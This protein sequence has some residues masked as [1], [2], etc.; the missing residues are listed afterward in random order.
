MARMRE[1]RKSIPLVGQGQCRAARWERWIAG[2]AAM[3]MLCAL[4]L[5]F[6]DAFFDINRFKVSFIRGTALACILALSLGLI[7]D[8]MRSH[9][10][11]C[12]RLGKMG[13]MLLAF[14]V[15]WIVSCAMQDFSEATLIGSEGRYCGLWCLLS[16]AL[17]FFVIQRGGFSGE[18]LAGAAVL[19]AAVCA[20][21]GIANALDVDPLHFY[22]RMMVGQKS[23]FLSTIGNVDF[24]GCY[25]AMLLPLSAALCAF[26]HR[27]TLALLLAPVTW[28]L[29]AGI[30][31]SRSDIAVCGA[32]LGL[33][34]LVAASGSDM[35]ALARAL[36]LWAGSWAALPIVRWLL[37]RGPSGYAYEGLLAALC[38]HPIAWTFCAALA[39]LGALC[40][41]L[42]IRGVRAPGRKRLLCVLIVLLILAFA[43]TLGLMVYF[44]FVDTSRDLGEMGYVLRFD[45]EWG[46]RRGFV[47]T[48]SLRALADYRPVEWLFGKG[49]ERTRAILTPYFDNPDMLAFGVFNDAHCQPLQFLLTCGLFGCLTFIAFHM[50]SLREIFKGIDGG[51]MAGVFASLFGYTLIAMLSVTQP[52]LIAVYLS[53]A[54]LAA[55]HLQRKGEMPHE[56]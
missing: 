21:L 31:A 24:F 2:A 13:A 41:L 42:R 4:P 47:Y 53:V 50:I 28:L 23:L 37:L 54:A 25:L 22:D 33:A 55:S 17:I 38:D 43:L 52:I 45:D 18:M 51:V 39:A 27:R 5:A 16:C 11:W 34:A 48:R 56:S 35:R 46:S 19:S 6:H 29:A 12:V 44:T 49:V 32:Q 10:G 15:S 36:V 8:E 1:K 7:V 30:C 20:T 3:A 26:A 9:G 14:A 40:F